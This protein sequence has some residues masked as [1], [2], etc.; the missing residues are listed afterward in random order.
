MIRICKICEA[1][2]TISDGEIEFYKSRLL[3]LPKRCPNC[4]PSKRKEMKRQE[5]SERVFQGPQ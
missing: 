2:F 5:E 3:D 4:R 1:E